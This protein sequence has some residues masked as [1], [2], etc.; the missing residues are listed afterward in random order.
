MKK[1]LTG[2]IVMG[3]SLLLLGGCGNTSSGEQETE[4]ESVAQVGL[5]TTDAGVVLEEVGSFEDNDFKVYDDEIYQ[6]TE[7]GKIFYD[8]LGRSLGEQYHDISVYNVYSFY[9]DYY[10]LN[11]TNRERPL[12]NMMTVEGEKLFAEDIEGMITRVNDVYAAVLFATG[13]TNNE[14]EALFYT[15]GDN[16]AIV[17]GPSSSD[18]FYTGYIQLYN[19]EKREYLPDKVLYMEAV[20][21]SVLTALEDGSVVLFDKEGNVVWDEFDESYNYG[22]SFFS[23]VTEGQVEILDEVM[24]P[25]FTVPEG[26]ELYEAGNCSSKFVVLENKRDV[27]LYDLEGNLIFEEP[28]ISCS[29]GNDDY[30]LVRREEDGYDYHL[31]YYP[32]KFYSEELY[33]SCSVNT[34]VQDYALCHGDGPDMIYHKD[35]VILQ[36]G[37]VSVTEWQNLVI[38]KQDENDTE[39]YHYYVLQDKD[40]TFDGKYSSGLID[41]LLPMHNGSYREYGLFELATGKQLF[42]Y[43]YEEFSMS[44]GYLYAKR[45]GVYTVYKVK[46]PFRTE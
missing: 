2:L 33:R 5:L 39:A 30:C 4:P 12:V 19:L 34:Y 31:F 9:Q 21:D 46:S 11:G 23:R 24:K 10:I 40:F 32:T 45:D 20:G 38:M 15:T 7:S 27:W 26:Y 22:G 16:M 41:G 17:N 14:E 35:E 43:A 13:T 6:E 29:G 8:Y 25:L 28:F 36:E 1:K 44:Y 3:M 37:S 18:T 42:D